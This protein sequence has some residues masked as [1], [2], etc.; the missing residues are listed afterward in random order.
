[1]ANCDLPAQRRV[2]S[3]AI[4]VAAR[5][6][7]C[8]VD[9]LPPCLWHCLCLQ[10]YLFLQSFDARSS[11]AAG[12]GCVNATRLHRCNTFALCKRG[13]ANLLLRRQCGMVHAV[14]P[15]EDPITQF[16][17]L[18]NTAWL[19]TALF[20]KAWWMYAAAL[21]I[22]CGLGR[23]L[24]SVLTMCGESGLHLAL[25]EPM[26]WVQGVVQEGCLPQSRRM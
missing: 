13:N 26:V 19:A 15:D 10:T 16:L 18:S 24:W 14:Y 21:S 6:E 4:A 20:Y 7:G 1:M 23:S 8:R 2:E 12:G 3:S 22:A 11:V 25:S 5:R 17:N 9:A